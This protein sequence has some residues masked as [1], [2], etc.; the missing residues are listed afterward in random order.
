MS[1]RPYL[2]HT[3]SPLHPGTGQATDIVDLPIARMA[4][5]G[6]PFLPGS[7]IKGVL[8]DARRSALAPE[9]LW[10]VFGP[11]TDNAG[12]HAGAFQVYDA[13]LLALPVRSFKGTFAWVTSPLL[14]RL[15]CR[16]LGAL[17]P[18]NVPVPA[19][20]SALYAANCLNV[21]SDHI[22]LVDLDLPA[23]DSN[24][25]T[26]WTK[27]LAPLVSPGGDI[28]SKRFVVVCDEIMTFLWETATQLDTRIRINSETGTVAQ[29]Q[30]WVEESLP[31]E[32]LLIG[33][34]IADKSRREG[35]NKTPNA[36]WSA[37]LPGECIL[38]LGGKASV[39]RGRCRVLP[40]GG[41]Q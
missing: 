7:S 23:T 1:I 36:V 18:G 11:E 20:Y 25:L 38:Q 8:R 3:L 26:P 21:H 35:K 2:I 13:R 16:D 14:L 40:M 32:T 9:D 15:A 12:L 37:A 33:I 34:A 39:G 5:T 22:Y 19:P 6:I 41:D 28:F 31:P 27:L 24:T 17:A 4:A 10:A 29:G 30:L